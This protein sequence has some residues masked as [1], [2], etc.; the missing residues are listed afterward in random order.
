M[1]DLE[2]A[3]LKIL[4][5]HGGDS[6]KAAEAIYDNG[7]ADVRDYALKVGLK[8]LAKLERRRLK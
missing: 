1:E 3:A 4:D 2:H 8:Q 5:Q 7:P 6:R